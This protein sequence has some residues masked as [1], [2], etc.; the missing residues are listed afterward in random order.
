V[1]EKGRARGRAAS[2]ERTPVLALSGAMLALAGAFAVIV[3]M[4]L[5]ACFVS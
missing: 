1:K 4:A 5:G 3:T 2:T